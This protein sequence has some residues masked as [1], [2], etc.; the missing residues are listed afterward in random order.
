MGSRTPPDRLALLFLGGL[1]A[2]FFAPA[3]TLRGV[4]FFGDAP[5]YAL[6]L[7]YTG[8]WLRAGHFPL[9]NPLLSL[10]APHAVDI[11]TQAFYPPHALLSVLLGRRV[12]DF[13]AAFH[14]LL[15]AVGTFWLAR[16]L[17]QSR[18]AA[19]LAAIAF[20]FGGFTFGHLQHLNILVAIA[21]IPIVLAATEIPPPHGI[22]ALRAWR[23]TGWRAVAERRALSSTH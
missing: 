3:L 17:G 22:A 23:R 20:A 13:A 12:Y 7:A 14:V 4:L 2:L 18:A 19:L 8:E 5:N 15:A 16:V 1:V 21:W 11:G 6:R 9:W 10:G